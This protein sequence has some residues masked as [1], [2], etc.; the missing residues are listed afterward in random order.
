MKIKKRKTSK[1]CTKVEQPIQIPETT[2]D[3]STVEGKKVHKCICGYTTRFST[4]MKNHL[5]KKKVCRDA[6]DPEFQALYDVYVLKHAV[7]TK[8]RNTC[9][10]CGKVFQCIKSIY[11]HA[12][13]CK[14]DDIAALKN[15]IREL[16]STQIP[17]DT[18]EQ[19]YSTP[20]SNIDELIEIIGD[21]LAYNVK[22]LLKAIDTHDGIANAKDTI[23]SVINGMMRCYVDQ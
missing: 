20:K 9:E 8:P 15:R 10:K 23:N 13:T 12:K 4:C 17:H 22:K 3:T 1:V 14:S 5:T 2:N 16:E 11:R 21:E 7:Q 19:T 18:P 6:S